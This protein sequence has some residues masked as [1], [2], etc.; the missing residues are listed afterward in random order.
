MMLKNN[1]TYP[2]IADQTGKGGLL[3]VVLLS[4]S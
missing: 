4:N 2:G 1:L 3:F